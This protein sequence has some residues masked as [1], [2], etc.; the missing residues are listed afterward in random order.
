[1]TGN[2]FLTLWDEIPLTE[3]LEALPSPLFDLLHKRTGPTRLDSLQTCLTGET[4][5]NLFWDCQ[6]CSRKPVQVPGQAP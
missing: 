6:V 5:A 3:T 2:V 4:A 1:M